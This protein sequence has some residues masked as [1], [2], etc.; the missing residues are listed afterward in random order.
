MRLFLF[1]LLPLLLAPSCADDDELTPLDQLPPATQTGENIVACLIDGEP[2]INDENRTGEVNISAFYDDRFNTITIN[3]TKSISDYTY[4]ALG[5]RIVPPK[6]GFQ[7]INP[8]SIV[9]TKTTSTNSNDYLITGSTF[10]FVN[11]THLGIEERIIA[12]TFEGIIVSENINDTIAITDGRFDV[13]F[14]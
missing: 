7:D 8:F 14:F 6:I 11:I 5:F 9:Y 1:L 13:T 2:W 12:G 10:C 3:S 4:S